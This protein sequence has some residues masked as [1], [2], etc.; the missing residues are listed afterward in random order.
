MPALLTPCE[1]LCC[2]AQPFGGQ[3]ETDRW[4]RGSDAAPSTSHP[5]NSSKAPH[6]KTSLCWVWQR[7][8][9]GCKYGASCVYAHGEA[10]LRP[11]QDSPS[12]MTRQV[13]A[14][15]PQ[16]PA[17]VPPKSSREAEQLVKRAMEEGDTNALRVGLEYLAREEQ[18]RDRHECRVIDLGCHVCLPCCLT[19]QQVRVLG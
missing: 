5:F 15:A 17:F 7:D 11:K 12:P 1:R 3:T 4:Q 13:S 6:F 9:Q 8:P 14:P 16:K 2:P 18:V 10:E 19:D